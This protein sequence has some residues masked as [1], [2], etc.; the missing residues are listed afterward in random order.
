MVMASTPIALSLTSF[1]L[2]LD[3]L[4]REST[5]GMAQELEGGMVKP[6]EA[7]PVEIRAGQ[8]LDSLQ[9]FGEVRGLRQRLHGIVGDDPALLKAPMVLETEIAAAARQF[10]PGLCLHH[11]RHHVGW[12]PASQQVRVSGIREKGELYG[13]GDP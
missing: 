4:S 9:P 8:S 12:H 6:R 5:R 2:R 11:Q 1:I 7:P 10:R 13:R 3:G